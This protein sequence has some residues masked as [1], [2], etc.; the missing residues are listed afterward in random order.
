MRVDS[1]IRT[2]VGRTRVYRPVRSCED[3]PHVEEVQRQKSEER[4]RRRK[5]TRPRPTLSRVPYP[6]PPVGFAEGLCDVM[7]KPCRLRTVLTVKLVDRV[8]RER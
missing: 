7:T 3:R 8:S 6:P 4:G 5:A 2:S 1:G